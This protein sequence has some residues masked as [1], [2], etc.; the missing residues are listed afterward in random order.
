MRDASTYR[1]ARRQRAK[2]LAVESGVSF[3]EH[4][5][6]SSLRRAPPPKLAAPYRGPSKYLPHQGKRE[7]ARRLIQSKEEG[8]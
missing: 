3:R 6:G 5:I 2:E 7:C 8:K 4:W 1:H